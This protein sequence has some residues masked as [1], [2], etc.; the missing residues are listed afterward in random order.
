MRE[1]MPTLAYAV[2]AQLARQPLTGY[3]LAARMRGAMAY[4]WAAPHSQIY[5]QLAALADAG[6]LSLRTSTGPGPRSKKT[7]RPT[8]DGL[9]AL[10]EWVAQPVQ[11]GVVRDELTLKAYAASA[12]DPTALAGMFHGEAQ[13]HRARLAEYREHERMLLAEHA[14]V[15]EDP[16]EPVF[17]NWSALRCGLLAEQAQ[18]EWCEW[19]VTR[20]SAAAG[21]PTNRAAR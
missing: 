10:A 16:S 9:A 12:A 1:R 15:L 3:Q 4:F 14:A 5:P 19:M 20:L 6:L 8:A 21:A 11:P 13:R 17:G 18:I 2:L 7:Y